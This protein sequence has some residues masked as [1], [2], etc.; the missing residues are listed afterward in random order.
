MVAVKG[1][2]VPDNLAED[3]CAA[4]ARAVKRFEHEHRGPLAHRQPVAARVCKESKPEKT[5]WFSA[6]YPPVTAR[7]AWPE[8]ISSQAC[9]MALAPDAQALESIVTGPLKPTASAT[10]RA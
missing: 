10:A 2:A 5:N 4:A 7:S 3:A 6:S 8:R 9:P 1:R